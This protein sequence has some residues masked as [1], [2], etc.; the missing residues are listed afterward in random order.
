[1][2]SDDTTERVDRSVLCEF[3]EAVYTNG[4]S[5]GVLGLFRRDVVMVFHEVIGIDMVSTVAGLP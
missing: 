2:H 5:S 3:F 4:Q 1:M